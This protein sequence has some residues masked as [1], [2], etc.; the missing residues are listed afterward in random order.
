MHV[1]SSESFLTSK[2]NKTKVFYK[3]TKQK[4][5]QLAMMSSAPNDHDDVGMGP[6]WLCFLCIKMYSF[7]GT[8]HIIL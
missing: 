6:L 7:F 5:L 8:L 3:Q 1:Y 4:I 2:Q